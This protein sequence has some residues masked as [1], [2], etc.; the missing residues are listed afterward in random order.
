[1]FRHLITFYVVAC[2]ACSDSEGTTPEQDAAI[3][4]DAYVKPEAGPGMSCANIA[5]ACHDVDPGTGPQ[6]DC[7]ELGH[8]GELTECQAREAEC[9]ALCQGGAAPTD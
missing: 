4:S 2:A 3:D 8:T 9:I 1:M 6:H 5:N 7:H